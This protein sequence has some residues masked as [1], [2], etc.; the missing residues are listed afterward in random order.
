MNRAERV[1]ALGRFFRWQLASRLLPYPVVLPFVDSLSLVVER[2]MTGATGNFY[3]G[4][5]E[6][7][8]MAFVLHALRPGDVFYDVGA[9]V[10]SYSLLAAAAGVGKVLAFEPSSET[11]LRLRKNL[12]W[13]A[14]QD[15]VTIQPVALGPC[16]GE[17]AF[18]RGAD[19]TNHVL[20]ED[21]QSAAVEVVPLGRFDTFFVP[22]A[23]AFIKVDVEGFESEVLAGA[24][25]S[26]KDPALFGLLIEDNGSHH[27]Y[28]KA[29]PVAALVG[30]FGFEEYRYDP[31]QR[32]LTRCSGAARHGNALFLRDIAA[33][34]ARVRAAPRFRLVNRWI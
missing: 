25:Q 24:A 21:E 14:L 2:G 32:T 16:E 6:A 4:L 19:T 10:G 34:A 13:N 9:N 31:E 11:A 17:I 3:C 7:A 8:D 1:S 12:R 22:G 30:E 15:V 26:L 33:I 5:H 23:P 20:A 29:Q 18:T 28:A 27:R